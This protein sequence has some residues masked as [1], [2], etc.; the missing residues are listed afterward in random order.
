MSQNFC[1]VPYF[2]TLIKFCNLPGLVF[3]PLTQRTI[4]KTKL[5]YINYLVEFLGHS[6]FPIMVVA[7]VYHHYCQRRFFF[8]PLIIGAGSSMPGGF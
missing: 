4:M 3:F 2:V 8:L 1:S 7:A 5:M 6:K